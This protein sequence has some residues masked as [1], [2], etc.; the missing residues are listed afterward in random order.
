MKLCRTVAPT[1]FSVVM[2]FTLCGTAHAQSAEPSAAQAYDQG[3]QEQ[4]VVGATELQ[5]GKSPLQSLLN[6][7]QNN[8]RAYKVAYVI[9]AQPGVYGS[10]GS[11]RE[12]RHPNVL[13]QNIQPNCN[14]V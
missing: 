11:H 5:R 6:F 13:T 12:R 3:M 4:L 8:K 1:G 14:F 10:S 7:G 9:V 2:G